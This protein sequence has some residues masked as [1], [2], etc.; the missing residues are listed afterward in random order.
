MSGLDK[1]RLVKITSTVETPGG[2]PSYV[3][4]TG[5]FATNDLVLTA[6]HVLADGN[7]KQISIFVESQPSK[8]RSAELQPVWRDTELDALLLRVDEPLTGVK[9]LEFLEPP[10]AKDAGDEEDE[11]EDVGDKEWRSAGYPIAAIQKGE[12]GQE[13][14]SIG[15]KGNLYG[16]GGGGQ[17]LRDL[18][19]DVDNPPAGNG[20]RGISGAPVFVDE[21]LAGIIKS[22][23]P[24]FEARRLAA[25][26][27]D[28]LVRSRGFLTSISPRWLLPSPDKPWCLVLVSEA[29]KSRKGELKYQVSAAIKS[30]ITQ[31][32]VMDIIEEPRM[33]DITQPLED[34][35]R[36]LEFVQAVCEAPFMVI[37][38]TD[39]EPAVMLMLGI[40]AVVRRGV[41]ITTT[42]TEVNER[43]LSALPFN[44]QEAKLISLEPGDHE[45]SSPRHPVNRLG[46]AILD[47]LT[48]LAD[49]PS[50]LDLPVYDAVRC[51]EPKAMF[52]DRPEG[53][54][55]AIHSGQSV[56]DTVLLLCPFRPI[57]EENRRLVANGILTVAARGPVRMLDM[58]SPRLVGQALYEHIRWSRFCIVDWTL[59][60]PNVFFELGVRLACS[61]IGPVSLI[62]NG[63]ADGPDQK[64][65]LKQHEQLENLLAPI[66][67]TKPQGLAPFITAWS[68]YES[69]IK[70]EREP[71]P[72]S[73]LEHDETYRS[74]AGGSYY[75][76]QEPITRSPHEQLLE[77]I[78]IQLG[79]DPQSAGK[80]PA[81]F[82][83]HPEFAMELQRNA[84]ER[85]IAAW[86][87]FLNRYSE[88]IGVKPGVRDHL[89]TLGEKVLQWLPKWPEYKRF[90]DE[91][92]D[93]IEE[94]YSMSEG[95]K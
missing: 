95:I 86:Y 29:Q 57:Y 74:I 39:F 65:Q 43:H 5:Y 35:A 78:E 7:A 51:P 89:I 83:S 49:Y 23:L 64:P 94:L 82:S 12:G 25:V 45:I 14:K 30:K 53:A 44:I 32:G 66:S 15:L 63:L 52:P 88:E 13:W 55:P 2:P 21:K 40:R 50:Y 54:A 80:F 34:R 4:G 90:R 20:W 19:L 33:V 68:S 70:R 37:D 67:Y 69:Y 31:A 27:I 41:T 26:P 56:Q 76:K 84:A 77:S 11:N 58:S 85:G 75:W 71:I 62:D 47:G 24:A 73:R 28:L 46:Q 81:L 10:P 79:K 16:L 93:K 87:Y 60:R 72:F 36:W 1:N 92:D 61:S 48:Q 42:S 38:V 3:H 18:D 8:W 9:P 22:H 6:N 59:W 17:G 91:I